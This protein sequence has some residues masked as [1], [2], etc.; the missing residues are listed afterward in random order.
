MKFGTLVKQSQ[1]FNRHY[2]HDNWCLICDFMEF[3]I[4]WKKDVVALTFV[5]FE[6][7]PSRFHALFSNNLNLWFYG[8]SNFLKKGRGSSNF[9]KIRA[10]SIKIAFFPF[11]KIFSKN[12]KPHKITNRASIVMKIVTNKGLWLFHWWTKF[13]ID[14]SSRLWVIA[15][16]NVE[17]R[18]HTHART[19]IYPDAS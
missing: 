10:P 11:F 17:N 5:K 15:V 19:H 13:H 3:W 4:F 18:T 2:F 8:I 16:W 1:H 14:I 7:H 6:L 12:L 9:R